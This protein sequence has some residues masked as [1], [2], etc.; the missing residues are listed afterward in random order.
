M[1][2]ESIRLQKLLKVSGP[3][4][5]II[6]KDIVSLLNHTINKEVPET[7]VATNNNT[8][9]VLGDAPTSLSS[10]LVEF[11]KYVQSLQNDCMNLKAQFLI[12]IFRKKSMLFL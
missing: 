2:L 6:K 7:N 11:L 4:G 1:A 3:N 10:Y 12:S 5:R 8:S 9:G